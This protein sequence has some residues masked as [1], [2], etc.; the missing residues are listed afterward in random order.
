M[1]FK[2]KNTI[3]QILNILLKRLIISNPLEREIC[4]SIIKDEF[5]NKM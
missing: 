5:L 4:S 1:K 3:N 2:M